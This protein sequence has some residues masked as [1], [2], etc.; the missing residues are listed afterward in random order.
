MSDTDQV[1][2]K[3]TLRTLAFVG[4][5]FGVFCFGSALYQVIEI[6]IDSGGWIWSFFL[7]IVSVIWALVLFRLSRPQQEPPNPA[8]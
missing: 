5:L 2:K 1:K 6:G 4:V 8:Q 3:W 7:G